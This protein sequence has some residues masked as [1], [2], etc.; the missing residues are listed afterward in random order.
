MSPD[1]KFDWED[2]TRI[3]ARTIRNACVHSMAVASLLEILCTDEEMPI[4]IRALSF[5][6]DEFDRGEDI[7][8]EK[9]LYALKWFLM[10]EVRSKRK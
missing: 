10:D 6:N 4:V 3:E 7:D 2:I 5:L 9:L 8:R 1:E